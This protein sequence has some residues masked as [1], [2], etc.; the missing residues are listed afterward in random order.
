LTST[1]FG[2]TIGVDRAH[3]I[4]LNSFDDLLSGP[5]LPAGTVSLLASLMRAPQGLE[6]FHQLV[7]S[8]IRRL[9]RGEHA[10][11]IL[12]AQ[13]AFESFVAV[14]VVES[15]GRQGRTPPDIDR[16][17][18]PGGAFHTLQRRL[19][20]LDR[21][22]ATRTAGTPSGA[23]LGSP[24]EKRW[25]ADLYSLRNRIIH[26]GIR[27]ISF[28]EAKSAIVVGLHAIAAIQALAPEFSRTMTWAGS[29]LDLPHIKQ[30]A[31]R[32]SRLF[33]S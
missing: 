30:S 7:L 17:M 24:D 31:G 14:L 19:Q 9:K 23:F 16:E 2:S 12:D 21:V 3:R 1:A 20:H 10:F 27:D 22:A 28:P 5:V 6:L 8:A 33:E 25:R 29:A 4:G 13:S 11:A 18:A 32:L 15:L 26:G